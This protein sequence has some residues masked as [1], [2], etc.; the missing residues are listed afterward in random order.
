MQLATSGP[1][2]GLM[3][4]ELSLRS[5]SEPGRIT[6]P[7]FVLSAQ[8]LCAPGA[9]GGLTALHKHNDVSGQMTPGERMAARRAFWGVQ[10][11]AEK[12]PVNFLL[13]TGSAIFALLKVVLDWG[14]R[15]TEACRPVRE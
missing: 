12:W 6:A 5:V 1:V 15:Q 7:G 4:K 13:F 2:T 8:K 14:G 3:Y 9:E 11:A 10:L